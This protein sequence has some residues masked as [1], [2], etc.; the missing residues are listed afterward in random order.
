MLCFDLFTIVIA[1]W[2]ED[3]LQ[4]P[5]PSVRVDYIML[6]DSIIQGSLEYIMATTGTSKGKV[7][8]ISDPITA[9]IIKTNVTNYLSDHFPV[10][11]SFILKAPEAYWRR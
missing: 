7:K 1:Q 6:S 8:A 4:S 2:P 10:H 9:S 11:V 3:V 5:A